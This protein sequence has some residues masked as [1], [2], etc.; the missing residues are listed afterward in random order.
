MGALMPLNIFLRQEIDR[1][2]RVI[3]VV[4]QTLSDLKLAIDGTIIMS[5]NLKDALD[6]MYDARVPRLWEKVSWES[7]TLGFWFTELIER[8]TQFRLP[9]CHAQEITR[10]H[11]GWALDSVVLHNDMTRFMKEDIASAPAEGVYVHGLF[12]DGAGWVAETADLWSHQ[13]K[14]LFTPLPVA[15]VYAINAT[16]TKDPRLYECPVYKKPRRTDLTYIFPL[17][18]KTVQHPDHWILRGVA[19]LCDTK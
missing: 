18:L 15:H 9:D 19:L 4:R 6:N 12:L 10:A 16:G 2:Q 1:M 14:I 3:T 11:K 5:E 8:N 13:P 17:L 7:T